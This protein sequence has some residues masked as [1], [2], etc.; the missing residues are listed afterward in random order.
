MLLLPTLQEPRV[1]LFR[2]K[3]C[4]QVLS[5]GL[6]V[7]VD[8]ATPQE[9]NGTLFE[10]VL[11]ITHKMQPSIVFLASYIRSDGEIVADYASVAVKLDFKNKVV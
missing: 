1:K 8:T 5:K 3:F 6:V 9:E 11:P 7:H 10:Y 4:A 2:R